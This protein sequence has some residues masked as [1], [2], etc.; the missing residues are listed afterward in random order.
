MVTTYICTRLTTT[1]SNECLHFTLIIMWSIWLLSL[2]FGDVHVFFVWEYSATYFTVVH[3]AD[4]FHHYHSLY[5]IHVFQLFFLFLHLNFQLWRLG[6]KLSGAHR[7]LVFYLLPSVVV[8]R[9]YLSVLPLHRLLVHRKLVL[10]F[11]HIFHST[12]LLLVLH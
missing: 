11:L 4:V 12:L 7:V 5:H 9:M 8:G 2:P 10:M 6:L 1:F 3:F